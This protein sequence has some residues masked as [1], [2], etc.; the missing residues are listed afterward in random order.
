MVRKVFVHVGLPKSGTTYLQAVFR[1]HRAQLQD[2]TG[3]LFPGRTWTDQVDAVREL[4]GLPVPAARRS[5][6]DG[7]WQRLVT[8]IQQWSADSFVSMEWLA[9]AHRDELER[10]VTDLAGREVHV[11]V[12]VRDIAR[13]VPAVW[14]E[15][16][17]T[18][19]VWTW[20]EYLE[21]VTSDDALLTP[22][23]GSF[24][25]QQDV[26]TVLDRWADLVPRDAV[27]VVTVPHPGSA[28]DELWRRLADVLE[29]EAEGYALDGLRANAS[30]G[31][32]SAELMRLV[33]VRVR[34][35][36]IDRLRYEA[37]FKHPL[38]KAHLAARRAEESRIALPSEL[39]KW[40][41]AVAEQQIDAIR[42]AGVRL[43]G[44]LEELQPAFG[45][46]HP[47][48]HPAPSEEP[49]LDGVLDAA[50]DALTSF[51]LARQAEKAEAAARVKR[52]RQELADLQRANDEL[53]AELD[54][55]LRWPIR[56]RR[57]G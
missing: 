10:I 52:L 24:W 14:Q 28:P 18:R 6:V 23:G 55:P 48:P 5:A 42:T 8:E 53:R 21:Q 7:A 37:A 22:A 30:L 19:G 57:H 44:S 41:M 3:V 29:I 45:C 33:N 32:E 2:R 43:V 26:R 16:T 13:T 9:A 56:V 40:A 17:Q 54:K 25:R 36:K 50:V 51:A 11:V 47:S 39:E 20:S 4:R 46:D 1:R 49:D 38:A 15:T 35:Q 27:H 31:R 12:T 34:E